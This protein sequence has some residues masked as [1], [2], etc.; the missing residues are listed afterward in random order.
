M[1]PLSPDLTKL[2]NEELHQKHGELQ[3]RMTFAYR[4]GNGDMVQQLALLIGDYDMEVQRRNQEIMDQI[5]KKSK[6]FGN[7]INISR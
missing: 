1:H 5:E 2:T 6:N 3:N 4:I 7:I